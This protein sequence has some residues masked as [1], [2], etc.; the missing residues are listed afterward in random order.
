MKHVSIF[1]TNGVLKH[2][3]HNHGVLHKYMFNNDR[4]MSHSVIIKTD[5]AMVKIEGC[6]M[7]TYIRTVKKIQQNRQLI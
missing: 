3:S 6:H 7:R 1:G 5:N 2:V 4:K